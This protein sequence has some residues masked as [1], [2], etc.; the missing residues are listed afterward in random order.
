MPPSEGGQRG[1]REFPE[2][3]LSLSAKSDFDCFIT[4][5]I[6]R[7]RVVCSIQSYPA[8]T[9]HCHGPYRH[10]HLLLSPSVNIGCPNSSNTASTLFFLSRAS[11]A[12]FTKRPAPDL[13]LRLPLEKRFPVPARLHPTS[14]T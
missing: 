1:D 13:R 6:L 14:R 2:M 8:T 4:V 5:S 10:S 11:G 7:L 12:R 3:P 9:Y